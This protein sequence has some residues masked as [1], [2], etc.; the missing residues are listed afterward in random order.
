MADQST[1]TPKVQTG[2]PMSFAVVTCRSV[3]KEL[4]PEAGMAQRQLHHS[5]PPQQVGQLT[6]LGTWIASS[7]PLNRLKSV[8]SRCLS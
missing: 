2:E 6:E 5:N 4:L 1:D 3:N 7:M 8:L